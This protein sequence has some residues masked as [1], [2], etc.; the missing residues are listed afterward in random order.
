MDL[1]L[2]DNMKAM[3]N[4]KTGAINVQSQI[5][6]ANNYGVEFRNEQYIFGCLHV[7]G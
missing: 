3:S 4:P 5:F 6:L 7:S 1:L 2:S